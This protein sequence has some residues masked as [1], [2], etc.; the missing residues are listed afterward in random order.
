MDSESGDLTLV[1]AAAAR[2]DIAARDQFVSAV[3]Q[4]LHRL[5]SGILSGEQH[6]VTMQTTALVH[7]ALIRLFGDKVISAN[8]R[9]H[10]LNVAA[11]QMRHILIDRARSYVAEKRKGF[12]VSIDDAC[13]LSSERSEELVALDDALNALAEVDPAAADVVE[14]KYFGGYTDEETAGILGIN[15]AKVRRDWTYARAWLH[16]YLSNA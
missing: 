16:E 4:Q 7:E 11:R 14:K 9:R 12:K 1:L 8:D 6:G 2:G 3:Y 5:A 10:F 13:Q 15:V